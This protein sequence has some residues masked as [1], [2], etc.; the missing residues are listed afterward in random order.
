MAA[1]VIAV[2]VVDS[3]AVDHEVVRLNT[4]RLN[5]RVLDGQT[6]DGR[7]V[8]RVGVEKLGLRFASVGAL[9]IPPTRTIAVDLGAVG[10]L[11]GDARAGNANQRSAPFLVAEGR[12]SLKDDLVGIVR[13][14]SRPVSL[15]IPWY[16]HSNRTGPASLLRG[17]RCH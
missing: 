2:R 8:K 16:R 15:P 11:D 14:G 4:D 7:V 3:H 10:R 12:G 5:G 13:S 1:V 9:A 6:R 17:P